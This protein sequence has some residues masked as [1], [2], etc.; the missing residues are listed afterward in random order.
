MKIIRRILFFLLAIIIILG[1]VVYLNGKNLYNIKTSEISINEKIASIRASENFT[2]LSTLPDYYKNAVIAVEDR[3]YYNHGAVDFI[4]LARAL[5][6]NISQKEFKEGG[7]S[8]T[9]QTAKNLYFMDSSNVISRK[10]A[11]I[12][13][14]YELEKKYSKDEILEIYINTIYFGNGYYGIK[15]ACNGYLNKDPTEMNISE[16]TML[17][18]VP[19][20]PSLYN[21][22][23]N[24]DLTI[25][26]QK[27]VISSMVENGYLSQEEANNI[28]LYN[29]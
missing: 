8:I 9:Q 18:G 29:N 4:A 20:A 14:S 13:M 27:K 15:E 26:R 28:V 5:V 21:P 24:I 25:S 2:S 10:S 7:S 6:K 11:E 17:A 3:R 22:R 1:T 16:A 19:N 23:A 12:I